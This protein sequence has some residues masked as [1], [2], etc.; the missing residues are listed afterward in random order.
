M[1]KPTIELSP[2]Q[3]ALGRRIF[4]AT[5]V[6]VT[7]AVGSAVVVT[8][9]VGQQIANEASRRAI[10]RAN[11]VQEVFQYQRL[12]QL[13]LAA[14]L[15]AGDRDFAAYFTEA[16][17][18]ND[19]LSLLDQLGERQNDLGYD[20][21]M[22]VD[23]QGRVIARTDDARP[24]NQDLSTEPLIAE[25]LDKFEAYGVWNKD[26][27]LFDTV[28]VPI[29]VGELLEGFLI[30]GFAIDDGTAVELRRISDT[31]V[32]LLAM[33]ED[34]VLAK[35]EDIVVVATTL[36]TGLQKELEAWAR[37]RP[38]RL[39]VDPEGEGR[40]EEVELG[41]RRWLA[42]VRP[43][44]NPL[45]D[46]VGAVVS[47][48][49]LEDQ[50]R[51]YRRIGKVLAGVGFLA[52]LAAVFLS[53]Q[54]AKRVL[55]PVAELAAATAAAA[56]GDYDRPLAVERRD[57]IG[58][59]AQ[60]FGALLSELREKRDMEAY[61]SE[62]SRNLP[63]PEVE[64]R[65]S[66]E[67]VPANSRQ[68]ALL[69]IEL[70]DG[71]ASPPAENS[72]RDLLDHLARELRTCAQAVA[73]HRGKVEAVLGHR[74]VASF[75]GD[76]GPRRALGTAVDLLVHAQS[77]T[78]SG[79]ALPV[80]VLVAG[81][82][83]SGTMAWGEQPPQLGLTGDPVGELEGLLRVAQPGHLLLSSSG[84][85]HLGETLAAAG[86]ELRAQRSSVSKHSLYNLGSQQLAGFVLP[87]TSTTQRLTQ[88]ATVGGGSP[89]LSSVGPGSLLG[90]RFEIL[91]VLG[92][93]GMGIVFK[94]RDLTLGELVALKMLKSMVFDD[95]EQLGRL[96]DELRLAR[97]IGH[98]NVLRTFDFGEVDGIP[99]LTME[100][101]LGITLR[102]LLETSGR[103]PLS[104]GL[105]L[106]RQLCRGLA[107]AHAEAVLHRDIKPENLI[108]EHTGNAKLMDFG[109]ARPITRAMPG[110]TQPGAVV[111]TPAYLA[112]EQL[113]G[114]EPD[115]RADLYACG[116]VFYEIFTGQL[117]FRGGSN[118]MK[119]IN[120]KLQEPP[121]PPREHWA[122]MPEV[123]ER[124]ILRCLELDRAARF[125]SATELLEELEKL[126]I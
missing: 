78:A 8:S 67:L 108:I 24:G 79:G 87:E 104:A 93:G 80:V 25:A 119:L 109:I 107:A 106:A 89:T 44:V 37:E 35:G 52:I 45:G 53:Y 16:K 38:G 62:L 46:S 55:A 103:L 124:L 113:S 114:E 33:G 75:D 43:L 32:S 110:Q 31:E 23:A 118:L 92:T 19:I 66:I 123:L 76:S 58:K 12:E 3:S 7:L 73:A 63:E 116:V 64:T 86:V 51:P 122:N 4:L 84:A 112:P 42:L 117:P 29:A 65:P 47:L 30:T 68:V 26:G 71:S 22:V 28:A 83:V 27:E 74:L 82:V 57:E 21:G 70:R 121:V 81:Q 111:G 5:A 85:D 54:I 96:K 39:V 125:S 98:P 101:V 15:L 34:T 49:S 90:D 77:T 11:L 18:T 14:Y 41:G 61:I 9:L 88:V 10:E 95:G 97:R 60:A 20:I 126:R 2:F 102:K 94:A 69:G 13:R 99:F 6:L 1:A 115:E 100:Y 36:E 40:R 72:P 59:L 91:S 50:L 120:E 56:D 17:A 105:R 48:A